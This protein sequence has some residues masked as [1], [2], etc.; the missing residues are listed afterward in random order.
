VYRFNEEAVRRLI[1]LLKIHDLSELNYEDKV[2]KVTLKRGISEQEEAGPKTKIKHE[3]PISLPSQVPPSALNQ[4][5]ARHPGAVKSQMVG[6]CYLAPSPGAPNFISEG[7]QVSTGQPLLI[8]EA[9]KV[10]NVI[11]APH[12]GT[13]IYVAVQDKSPIEF[14]QLLVVIEE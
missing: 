14:G 10:M 4:D 7:Q 3:G 13:I 2:L 11:K 5:Y 1:E 12:D 9:M 6:T 8:I